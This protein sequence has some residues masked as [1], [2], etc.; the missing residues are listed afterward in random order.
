MI[1]IVDTIGSPDRGIL[2][3]DKIGSPDR[4]ILCVDKIGSSENPHHPVGAKVWV[5]E[6]C[7]LRQD[8]PHLFIYY[9]KSDHYSIV[10]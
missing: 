1:V 7:H 6:N 4:G 2:C 8:R 3:V 10:K 9:L 5:L